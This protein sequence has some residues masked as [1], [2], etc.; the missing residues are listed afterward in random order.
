MKLMKNI[1]SFFVAIIFVL[2]VV[3][4]RNSNQRDLKSHGVLIQAYITRV[5]YGGKSSSGFNCL[6]N[7]NNKTFQRPT[8]STVKR[9]RSYFVNKTFPAMYSPASDILEILMTPEDFS[10]FNLPFPDS[11]RWVVDYLNK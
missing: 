9:N 3:D 6:I 7:Y 5:N 4:W 10:K 2:I 11:L 8:P 1:V